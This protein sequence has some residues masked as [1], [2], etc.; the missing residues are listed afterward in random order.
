M[1]WRDNVALT[2]CW[3]SS[4]AGTAWTIC[5]PAK[6]LSGPTDG[7]NLVCRR[8]EMFDGLV[9][10]RH[11]R[12]VVAAREQMHDGEQRNCRGESGLLAAEIPCRPYKRRRV[13]IVH[14]CTV[15]RYVEKACVFSGG[16]HLP[17]SPRVSIR[18]RSI[19]R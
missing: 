11:R 3:K 10:V 2:A 4:P 1:S 15:E 8:K 5:Q 12:I 14:G 9:D 16:N 18:S 7:T 17:L 6:F 19:C 13:R